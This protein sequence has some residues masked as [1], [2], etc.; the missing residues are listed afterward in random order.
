MGAMVP[1]VVAQTAFESVNPLI[2]TAND[3]N[4]FPGA[5]APFGMIQWSPDTTNGWYHY[6]EG[7]IRG[8]SLTHLSGGRVSDPGRHAD[9]AVE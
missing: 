1:A 9:A 6:G 7:T 4:T 5:S 8:F 3:G 2:G